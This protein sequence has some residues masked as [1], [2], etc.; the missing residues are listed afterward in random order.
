M[1]C[2]PFATVWVHL[3]FFVKS[4]FLI[5]LVLCFVMCCVVY[6]LF[7][8][9]LCIVWPMLPVFLG[10]SLL[11]ALRFCLTF[12][13]IKLISVQL[14][15]G[16]DYFVVLYLYCMLFCRLFFKSNCKLC[17]IF[18]CIICY[19]VKYWFAGCS[20][21]RPRL[22]L[23]DVFYVFVGK[24]LR[25]HISSYLALCVCNNFF[26]MFPQYS[27]IFNQEVILISI[28]NLEIYRS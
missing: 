8:R 28:K 18:M 24:Y 16:F 15:D 12:I 11:I 5:F 26:L 20:N 22:T 23:L 27:F 17:Y 21:R 6:V 4:R 13:F 10:C 14:L 25:K 9:V 19:P 3:G 1:H 2:L 7:V